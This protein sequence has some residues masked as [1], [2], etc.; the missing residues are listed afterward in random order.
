MSVLQIYT[1]ARRARSGEERVEGGEE[2]NVGDGREIVRGKVN[3]RSEGGIDES[4]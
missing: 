4:G 1:V 3:G 2:T